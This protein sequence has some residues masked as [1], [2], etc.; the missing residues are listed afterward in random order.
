MDAS[1]VI[2]I[3]KQFESFNCNNRSDLAQGMKKILF[4]ILFLLSY[5]FFI[6]PAWTESETSPF[7][8]SMLNKAVPTI[9]QEIS[10]DLPEWVKRTD[11]TLDFQEDLKP[12]WSFETIQPLYRSRDTF[13]H[14]IFIQDRYAHT[15]VDDTINIGFGYRYF[16][17]DENWLLGVNS[18][19]DYAFDRRHKRY[20]MGA[21]IISKFASV[22]ANYYEA[23]SSWRYYME[24]GGAVQEKALDGWDVE[25]K[26]QVPYMPWIQAAFKGYGWQGEKHNDVEG[27]SMSCLMNITRNIVLEFGRND[28]DVGENNF[29]KVSFTIGGPRRV[30]YT[31]IDNFFMPTMFTTYDLKRKTLSKVRRHHDIVVEKVRTSRGTGGGGVFIGRGT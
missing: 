14:T 5:V 27:Y 26:M 20:G 4:F 25:G 29:I 16:T 31:M 1:L 15:S 6:S 22:H 28:D 9:V 11:F 19:Y 17:P 24:T 7:L 23:F 30:E 18:F 10:D 8:A 3:L 12:L 21:E 13:R 2:T